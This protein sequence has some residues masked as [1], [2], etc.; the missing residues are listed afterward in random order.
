MP[1]SG[2]ERVRAILAG[3]PADRCGYWTGDPKPETVR[4]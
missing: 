4:E 1:M 3:E 2:R